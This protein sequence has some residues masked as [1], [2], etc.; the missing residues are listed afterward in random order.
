LWSGGRNERTTV[1]IVGQ[2]VESAPVQH[3]LRKG[4]AIIARDEIE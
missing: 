3:A 4:A 1:W 2:F